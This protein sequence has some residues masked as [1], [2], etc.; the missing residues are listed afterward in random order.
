MVL[1]IGLTSVTS[2]KVEELQKS[3]RIAFNERQKRS[4]KEDCSNS[5]ND[6]LNESNSYFPRIA[7]DPN[8]CKDNEPIQCD[9]DCPYRPIDGTCNN[10][11]YPTWGSAGECFLRFLSPSYTGYGDYRRSV[12]G[13]PLPEVRQVCLNIFRKPT[14]NQEEERASLLMTIYGQT[15]AHD[16]SQ[17]IQDES[18]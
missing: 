17:A 3:Y 15:V 2:L 14:S 7:D 9:P 8:Q 18:E 12:K 5:Y 11:Q 1:I 6:V 16:M 10:L 4:P 13:G